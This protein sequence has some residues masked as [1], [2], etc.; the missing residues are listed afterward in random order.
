ME[1]TPHV[2]VT[3]EHATAIGRGARADG[4]HSL[5]IG[6]GAWARMDHE[7]CIWPRGAPLPLSFSLDDRAHRE[8]VV[9][10]QAAYVDGLPWASDVTA[11]VSA[12][13]LRAQQLHGEGYASDH[14]A[15]AVLQEE[16]EEVWDWVKEKRAERDRAAMVK[17]LVQVAAVAVK[18]AEQLEAA[19]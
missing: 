5:A 18:W 7:I 4:P 9:A 11:R 10:A 16:V 2:T 12:E 15:Y 3:A 14:E 1:P 8:V 17:E 6:D 13:V 19:T